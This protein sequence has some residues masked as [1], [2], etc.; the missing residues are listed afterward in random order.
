MKFIVT[1]G[2]GFIG[3]NVVQQLELQGHECFVID[4]ITGYNVIAKD[5]LR[6]LS[7]AR[8]NQIHAAVHHI[9][10]Q[11]Q[12]QLESFFLCF[13]GG[14]G[15]VVHLAESSNLPTSDP[16]FAGL[17]KL[18]ELTKTHGI[19]KFVY[20]SSTDVYRTPASQF[21]S[22]KLTGE[23]IVKDFSS[24]ISYTILRPSTVYGPRS[25]ETNLVS[26]FIISAM[27]DQTIEVANGT[28]DLVHVKDV[29][30]GIASAAVS[31]NTA[32]NTYNLAKSTNSRLIDVANLAVTIAGRGTVNVAEDLAESNTVL[33]ISDTQRDFGYNP[34]IDLE[35]GMLTVYQWLTTKIN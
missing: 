16:N 27:R 17:R 15:A 22:T 14:I 1:G 34:K 35:T 19:P 4:K 5:E 26:K 11:D 28:L 23:R 2:A 6:Y 13:G 20:V 18:L 3:H 33:D 25:V 10:I 31:K 24:G 29:S 12:K 7:Q 30:L 21:G 9:D 32:N 8:K